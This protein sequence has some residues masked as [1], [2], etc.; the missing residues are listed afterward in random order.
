MRRVYMRE[1]AV[2][3]VLA[4][5]GARFFPSAAVVG[6]A[7]KPPRRIRRFAV[8]E[9]DWVL[10]AIDRVAAL[11]WMNVPRLPQALAA[12]A[13]LRRRGIASR[14]CLGGGGDETT[15]SAW[16][17]AGEDDVTETSAASRAFSPR[18]V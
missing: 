17:V 1:A 3:L 14:L 12:H 7:E 11:P 18:S 4:R 2:M 9:I 10:W 15:A 6:W 13:M 8:D 5:L 16:L